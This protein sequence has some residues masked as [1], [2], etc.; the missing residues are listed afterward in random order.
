M[1]FIVRERAGVFAGQ[2]PG[3][4]FELQIVQVGVQWNSRIV[5][6]DFSRMNRA[7]LHVEIKNSIWNTFCAGSPSRWQIAAALRVDS[8]AKHWLIENEFAELDLA[9]QKRKEPDAQVKAFSL[10]KRGLL[11]R[12]PLCTANRNSFSF[13]AEAAPEHF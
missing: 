8:Q 6:I 11:S 10:K 7:V 12:S 5:V 13:Q 1:A 3:A 9:P 2:G 4:R